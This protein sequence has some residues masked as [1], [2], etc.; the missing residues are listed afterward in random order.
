[1]AEV[2]SSGAAKQT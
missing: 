1:M 2:S